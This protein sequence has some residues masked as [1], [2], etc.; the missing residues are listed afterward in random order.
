MSNI[1]DKKYLII[2]DDILNCEEFA[3]MREVKHHDSNRLQHSLRVSYYSYKLAKKLHLDYVSVA[4]GGLLHD[5]FNERTVDYKKTRDKIK[6]YTTNHPKMAVKN[7]KKYFEIN[8]IEE[9]I[10]KSHMFPIDIKIP[11]FAE[12]WVVSGVDKAVSIYEFSKKFSHKL[13][14]VSNFALLFLINML[15]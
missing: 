15:K 8:N 4:R 5:F 13:S 9:D 12:S 14:Y 2:V 10:I 7:A 1:K 6:L 11:K 3:K